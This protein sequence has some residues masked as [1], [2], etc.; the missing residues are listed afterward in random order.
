MNR[1]T[2]EW[3]R[4]A[5]TDLRVVQLADRETEPMNDVIC[6]HCQQSA[7][8][9][10]KALLQESGQPVPR[11]HNLVALKELLL[12]IHPSIRPLGRGLDFMTRFAVDA[13]YPGHT[14]TRRQATSALQWAGRVR[15]KCRELL[16]I[17]PKPPRHRS[18]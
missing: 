8:K 12:P 16:G 13:R 6:F 10:L 5:E 7:E 17:R 15:E 3:I 11:I 18:P 14:V 2:R 4:K 9:Y 1:L